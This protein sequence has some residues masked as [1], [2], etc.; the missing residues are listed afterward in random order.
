MPQVAYTYPFEG[1]LCLVSIHIWPPKTYPNLGYGMPTNTPYLVYGM[2]LEIWG[3]EHYL[4]YG[5]KKY[6]IFSFIIYPK[7][8]GFHTPNLVYFEAFGWAPVRSMLS[9]AFHHLMPR[10]KSKFVFRTQDLRS[11]WQVVISF[12]SILP[13]GQ[14]IPRPE[15]LHFGAQLP[16]PLEVS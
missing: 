3:M 16:E 4:A 13:Q 7:I 9:C 6:H 10:S 8:L 11:S 2:G 5:N 1:I 15:G 12:H 14:F